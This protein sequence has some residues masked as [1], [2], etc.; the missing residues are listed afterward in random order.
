M[1]RGS[2]IVIML[3]LCLVL[4]GQEFDVYRISPYPTLEERDSLLNPFTLKYSPLGQKG[5]TLRD[6]VYFFFWNPGNSSWIR[7]SSSLYTYD[8]N[9]NR[10]T[11]LKREWIANSW[12]DTLQYIYYYDDKGNR[13]KEVEQAWSSSEQTWINKQQKLFSFN[14]YQNVNNY[15]VQDWNGMLSSWEDSLQYL[16]GYDEDQNWI[17]WE[18]KTWYPDSL[19][20]I[21]NYRFIYTYNEENLIEE[22]RQNWNNTDSA[23]IN[24]VRDEYQYNEQNNLVKHI[25]SIWQIAESTWQEK[26]VV[27]F[28][29]NQD[30]QVIEKLYKSWIDESFNNFVLYTYNYTEFG[31]VYE[32]VGFLWHT[33]NWDFYVRYLFDYDQ[34]GTLIRET[35]QVWSEGEADWI[36]EYKW[37]YYYTHFMEPLHA[38]ISDSTNVS[39]Y[40]YSDGTAT[41]TI[42]GGIPPYSI[43]WN[44]P[45]NTTAQT[46]YGLSADQYYTVTVT[47]AALNSVSDSV[48]LSQPP[49][50]ITGPIYG[51]VDV[52]QFDTVTYWVESDPSS[53][54]S[55]FVTKG[56]ILSVQGGDTIVIVWTHAGQGKISVFETTT[57]GC[58][59]DTVHL[60]VSIEP[61]SIV[62][63]PSVRL[64]IYPNPANQ[65]ITIQNAAVEFNP[66]NL[67][68]LDMTGKTIQSYHDITQ[69]KF[70]VPLNNMSQGIY[71]FRITNRSGIEIRKVIVER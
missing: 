46:V 31:G 11:T 58:E 42:A 40:G 3:M 22:V 34:Q 7:S 51:K 45:Q 47:D 55:W 61:T 71:F 13:V 41:V 2:I 12:E 28:L 6:S 44:D 64:Q 67:E 54:Y 63:L 60:S 9:H 21:S 65:W 50:I 43:L 30:E 57:N 33:T 53:F 59:G 8:E 17:Y 62:K 24:Y 4:T 10:I 32:I 37:E 69:D 36:N 49:E 35:D 70:Q 25:Q 26:T 23:W 56:Q 29:Y 68:I 39:C 14:E 16:Y 1:K 5:I 20:W 38:F 18:K 19:M 52:N 27:S 15:I 48:M 66:W